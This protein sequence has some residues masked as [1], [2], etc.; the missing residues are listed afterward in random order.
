MAYKIVVSNRFSQKLGKIFSYLEQ[1]FPEKISEDFLENIDKKLHLLI[2]QPD[3]GIASSK[4]KDVR[5]ISLT[6]FDK[7]YYQV[8]GRKII[9]LDMLKTTG[10]TDENIMPD[11]NSL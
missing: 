7:L 9:L 4:I 3:I 2:N 1:N 5:K 11:N 8:K 10:K 6:R